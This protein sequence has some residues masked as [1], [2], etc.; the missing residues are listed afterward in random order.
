MAD[1]TA[2]LIASY[3]HSGSF[4][5]TWEDISCYPP[6]PFSSHFDGLWS[7]HAVIL[8]LIYV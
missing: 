3:D 1:H 8:G 4:A 5:K 2:S 6:L 7:R